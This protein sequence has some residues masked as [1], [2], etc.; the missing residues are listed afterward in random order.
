VDAR[1][2]DE[3]RQIRE[4][5]E[6]LARQLGPA[7]PESLPARDDGRKAWSRLAELGFLGLRIPEEAGGSL[8]SGV[9]VALV[10]EQL[11]RFS[12]PLPFIG[13]AVCASELLRAAGA[14]KDVLSALADGSLRLAPVVDPSMRRWARPGEAGIAFESRG[15]AAGLVV[16]PETACLRAVELGPVAESQDLTRELRRIDAE[17]PTLDVG[18]LGSPVSP[19]ARGRA[20][21]LTLSALAADLVGVMQAALDLAVAYT[22]EREQFGVKVGTFQ[23]LQHMAAEA[24]VSV[25]AAR[26]CAWHAAWS[27]DA[28]PTQ[29]A[30][31]SAHAAKAYTSEQAREVCET[32]IQ[33]HGGIGMTWEAMP[34]VHL[35]RALLGR[36][37]LGDEQA[38]YA[39]LADLRLVR[40]EETR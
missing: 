19:D 24:L 35:R 33:M 10:A 5:A 38:H 40:P 7:S 30:L 9:E 8:L 34:H 23:A 22:G 31:E 27:V 1:L 29:K 20:L 37:M 21:A 14:G 4:T 12:V 25:E 3:Q 2:S 17:A 16:E 15:A 28:L 26:G 13:S 39:R 32:G 6:Q 11:G 36:L 18:D